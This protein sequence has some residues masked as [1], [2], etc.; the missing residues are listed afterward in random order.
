MNTPVITYKCKPWSEKEIATLRYMVKQDFTYEEIGKE[1][2]RT[3][4]GCSGKA[5][6]LNLRPVK[7]WT[8]KEDEV[9][10]RLY[11]DGYTYKEISNQL[12]GRTWVTCK[13]RMDSLRRKGEVIERKKVTSCPPDPTEKI[14]SLLNQQK[15]NST[16]PVTSLVRNQP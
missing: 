9:L 10:K 12:P 6:E 16:G 15:R 2:G 7:Y 3:K 8:T 5:R 13:G 1:L 4:N 11:R 14:A